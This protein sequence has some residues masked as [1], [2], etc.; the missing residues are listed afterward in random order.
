MDT[1]VAPFG[2][3]FTMELKRKQMGKKER[4]AGQTLIGITK[5]LC[6]KH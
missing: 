1:I 5:R 3:E 4:E 2:M 6:L